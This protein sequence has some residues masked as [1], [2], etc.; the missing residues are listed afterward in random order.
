M[1]IASDLTSAFKYLNGNKIAH[2][3][4]FLPKSQPYCWDWWNLYKM[5]EI[6]PRSCHDVWVFLNLS[7]IV[8]RLPISCQECWDLA[9]LERLLRSCHDVCVF[10]NL[11]KILP[12]VGKTQT[13]MAGS[14]KTCWSDLWLNCVH[15]TIISKVQNLTSG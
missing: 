1:Q 2:W 5:G 3:S 4:I 13:R 7:E 12:R 11:G 15:W 9:M 14:F 10:L 6:S 8:A